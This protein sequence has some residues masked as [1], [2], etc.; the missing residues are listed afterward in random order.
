MHDK[1]H[2]ERLLL[3]KLRNLLHYYLIVTVAQIISKFIPDKKDTALFEMI[4][5]YD[6]LNPLFE[7]LYVVDKTPV[8]GSNHLSNSLSGSQIAVL[9]SRNQLIYITIILAKYGRI[10]HMLPVDVFIVQL[11]FYAILKRS[12]S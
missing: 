1:A 7:G 5:C 12:Y 3:A 11:C 8:I 6:F 2:K 10:Q 4:G 9:N